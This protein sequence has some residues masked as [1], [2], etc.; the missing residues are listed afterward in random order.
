MTSLEPS[1]RRLVE[2][3]RRS[4][5]PENVQD[6]RYTWD[7][8]RLRIERDGTRAQYLA[9][10]GNTLALIAFGF[11]LTHLEVLAGA[12]GLD[13]E[14]ESWTLATEGPLGV[15]YRVRSKPPEPHPLHEQ[16]AR[17]HTDRRVFVAPT[18]SDALT[19]DLTAACHGTTLQ[20]VNPLSK[21][22][23]R[24]VADSEIGFMS[25]DRA[26]N[27]LLGWTRHTLE[28]ADAL[29]DGVFWKAWSLP[30]SALFF[31]ARPALFHLGPYVGANFFV[32]R[33][34]HARLRTA[35]LVTFRPPLGP[36]HR[37][38]LQALLDTGRDTMRVWFHLVRAG[39]SVHPFALATLA[40]YFH[41]RDMIDVPALR[42]FGE[43]GAEAAKLIDG[44]TPPAGEALF[45]LRVGLP[46]ET[47][48]A[49]WKTRRKPLDHFLAAPEVGA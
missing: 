35:A 42:R 18:F 20:I 27:L 22:L 34:F 6:W 15:T 49:E 37:D 44:D 4:P 16:V 9:N 38:N 25:D 10:R 48:P 41:A 40:S 5:T 31:M 46:P 12:E 2:A 23:I 33:L 13:L 45:M 36:D 28:E 14:A 43:V 1:I 47:Y 29:K 19:A 8:T 11:L 21:P 32:R 30:R 17:R 24:R 3:A 26:R 7:G 39:M